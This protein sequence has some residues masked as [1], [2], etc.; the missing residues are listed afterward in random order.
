M[1]SVFRRAFR[2]ARGQSDSQ[3]Q[4]QNAPIYLIA[5]AGQPNF[6]DEFIARSWLDWLAENH[7]EREVWLDC[8]E[9]GRAAHFFRDTHPKLRT[10]NTLWQTA[11]DGG[12]DDIVEAAERVERLVIGLGS[13]K[14]DLGLRDLRHMGSLHLLGGGYMNTLWPK[15]L[16]ILA[17]MV[18]V[19]KHFDVPIYAT[20]QGLL[21][22][23]E[24]SHQVTSEQLG[25]FDYVEARDA[26][27]AEAFDVHAGT[28]DAF[29]AFANQRAIYAPEQA[30]PSKMVLIQGDMFADEQSDDLERLITEFVRPGDSPADVGFA[31]AIPPED[32]RFA[33]PHVDAGMQMFPFMRMWE[34]GF[35]AAQGQEWLTSRFHFHL[36]AA[37]AGARGTIVNA[38]AGYYDVKHDL[39]RALGTGW[40]TQD[41]FGRHGVS[42]PTAGDGF[43]ELA[44]RLG[45]E[46]ARLARQ[47]YP[48]AR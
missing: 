38:R 22:Y 34:E 15:N 6:G 43:P 3:E 37:A 47:L 11:H 7:P 48:A 23:D 29:L 30:V 35:P 45:A 33:S 40:S 24:Q 46:K 21:P 20:G 42:A 39:L 16:A 4:D 44:R 31:E 18:T 10:T 2:R 8:M 19:K 36:L 26:P 32:A 25:Q 28:D 17:A 27:S 41:D 5:A 1:T 13:P 14:N 9:P 12:P